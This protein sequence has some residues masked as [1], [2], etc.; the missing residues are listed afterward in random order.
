MKKI[1]FNFIMRLMHT[2]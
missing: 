2:W 1:N